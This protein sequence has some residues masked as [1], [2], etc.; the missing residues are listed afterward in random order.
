MMEKQ[1]LLTNYRAL[2]LELE[3]LEMQL[4]QTGTDGRPAGCRG[5]SAGRTYSRTNDPMAAMVQLADGLEALAQCKREELAALAPEV[6]RL[7]ERIRDVRTYLIVQR[8]YVQGQ[9]DGEISLDMQLSRQRVSQLRRA[10][11][12]SL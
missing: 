1:E 7:M 9:T 5:A 8:Y 4:R 11:V 2:V 12:C 3:E 6:Q 10:Y